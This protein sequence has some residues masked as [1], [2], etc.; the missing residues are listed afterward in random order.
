MNENW[1]SS[2]E[3]LDIMDLFVSMLECSN[4]TYQAS[5]DRSKTWLRWTMCNMI[6]KG[7]LVGLA[8][9]DRGNGE[10]QVERLWSDKPH[11]AEKLK[12]D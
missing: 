5:E 11:M 3:K 8:L 9:M 6:V 7:K 1:F 4:Q 2:Q 10:G 12:R